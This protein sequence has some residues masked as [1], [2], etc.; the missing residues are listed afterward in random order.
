LREAK[1]KCKMK[2]IFLNVTEVVKD[3]DPHFCHQDQLP[4]CAATFQSPT[5][6]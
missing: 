2:T 6:H 5:Q 4:Q 3:D 1:G